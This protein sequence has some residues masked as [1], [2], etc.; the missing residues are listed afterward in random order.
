M[1]GVIAAV[2]LGE[3]AQNSIRVVQPT[4]RVIDVTLGTGET[5][6]SVLSGFGLDAGAA[7]AVG[8]SLRP[9]VK[10]HEIRSGKRLRVIVDAKDGIMQ[11]LEYPLRESVLSVT[12]TPGG[13]SAERREIGRAHVYSSHHQISHTPFF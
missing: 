8:E 5:L 2:Q 11:G 10:Q 6:G 12:S 13:W 4:A 1:V 3:R 7:R 9:Y